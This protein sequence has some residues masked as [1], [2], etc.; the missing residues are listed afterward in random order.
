[1]RIACCQF[2][3]E[4]HRPAHN[5]AFAAEAIAAAVADGAQLVVAGPAQYVAALL[6]V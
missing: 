4:V 2:A 1:V 3:P 6:D 5:A